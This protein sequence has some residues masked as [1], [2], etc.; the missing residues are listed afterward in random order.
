MDTKIVLIIGPSGAGK[1]TL[2]KEA[3]KEFKEKINFV[4]RY[5]TRESDVNESNYY[6]DEYAFEILRHNSYFASS[7]N[8]HG[9]FYG[10][11]KRFIKNG[12]NLISISRGRIK[13]FENLYDKV[14]TINITLPKE[15]LK[16]RLLK[17]G[18]E[19]KED[20]EKRVQR[21]YEKIEA[22]N[23]IEFDNL[24]SIEDSKKNFIS[25]LKRIE[26]E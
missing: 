1:D 26:N 6:I 16:Q 20:I 13:D 9:N 23:L 2:I 7:W 12:I 22:K 18:R 21:E 25:L 15:I 5:I 14:Y 11:P 24:A 19:N 8:A 10:I 4:K 3:K 17:R